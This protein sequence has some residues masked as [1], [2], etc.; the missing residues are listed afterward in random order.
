MIEPE[1]IS[2]T[3]SR[4][5]R[6]LFALLCLM[7]VL[8]QHCSLAV[9]DEVPRLW[10]VS[11][12]N[13]RGVGGKFFILPVT[14]NGLAVEYDEYFYKTVVPIAMSVDIFLHEA[15]HMFPNEAPACETSLSDTAENREILRKAFADVER[16]S[17]EFRGPAPDPGGLSEQDRIDLLQMSHKVAHDSVKN[18]TEYGL[19][20]AMDMYLTST[21]LQ[22]PEKSQK[23]GVEYS[24]RPIVA[25]YLKQQ[26]IKLDANSRN[27]SIDEKFDI[28]QAYCHM[29]DLRARYLRRQIEWL[30]PA[31]FRP[32]TTEEIAKF[33]AGFVDSIRKGYMSEIL[34]AFP[35]L[36]TEFNEKIICERNEKW[37]ERM[38]TNIGKGIR[39]YAVGMSHVLQPPLNVPRCD[40]LLVRLRKE[41]FA[42]NLV[43]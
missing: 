35:T 37:L 23:E 33:N 3:R 34:S 5:L 39:F 36:A 2:M 22:H 41:G 29:G 17:F 13:G 21:H 38:R 7:G 18:L 24:S 16:A 32:P 43:N 20:T 4:L 1:V 15:S 10:E 27:E 12:K 19:L 11:G 8:V 14:H 40:G 42:V 26:R 9:A 6:K 25:P 28:L 31:K 30:D